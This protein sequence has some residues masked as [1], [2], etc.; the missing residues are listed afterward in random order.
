MRLS[1]SCSLTR[2]AHRNTAISMAITTASAPT[3][4]PYTPNDPAS[5]ETVTR[6]T[7]PAGLRRYGIASGKTACCIGSLL[8]RVPL[9]RSGPCGLRTIETA[10]ISRMIPL[11]TPSAP[12]E[13][14]SSLVKSPPR[15][16]KRTATVVAVV[17]IFRTM[18]PLV[19]AGMPAVT[20]RKGHQRD[21]GP[22]ADQEQEENVDHPSCVDR[23]ELHAPPSRFGQSS[24]AAR[25]H[26][27]TPAG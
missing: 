13:K 23:F 27:V 12:G 18:R 17:S 9:A 16:S 26:G 15:T 3:T 19:A 2:L 4:T 22:N 24:P 6:T 21:L 20:S 1:S 5:A 7:I 10:M 11:D 25:L 14:C 8:V